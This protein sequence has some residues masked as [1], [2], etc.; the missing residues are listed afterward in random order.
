M[1]VIRGTQVVCDVAPTVNNASK[2]VVE[3]GNQSGQW[4][5]L[6]DH[7]GQ[8][9]CGP[10]PQFGVGVSLVAHKRRVSP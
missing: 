5:V 9:G 1:R 2:C 10:A 3:S 6:I 4:R 7:C 8:T